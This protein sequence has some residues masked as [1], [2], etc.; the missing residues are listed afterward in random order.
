MADRVVAVPAPSE[1]EAI[2]VELA[3]LAG[4]LAL[5]RR[6]AGFS[7]GTKSSETDVVTDV[8]RAVERF[9]VDELARRRP[10]DIVLGE[11]GGE[12]SSRG[13]AV[14]WIV[15]PID[16]T[17]NFMLGLPVWSVS[18]AAETAEGT[19]AGCVHNPGAG[20]TFH[21]ARGSGAYLGTRR[22]SGPRSVAVSEAVVATGFGY[23][24]GRRARQGEVAGRLLG[25]VGNLR[26]LGSAALDLCALAAGWVD[27]YYEG[28]LNEWDLAAG[29]LI[30]EEA[31]VALSGLRGRPPGPRL[32]AGAH[33]DH[34]AEFF[35]LLEQLGA[36]ETG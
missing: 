25:H 3:T 34:A 29:V 27:M 8:D 17:V 16:G 18:I 15:D 13:S 36:D 33:A 31:G 32:V 22:L 20:A 12:T 10:S 14:R 9:I 24:A 7:V 19:V 28:P 35:G 23:D 26:R 4:Q 11:E 2:A 21:A 5:D 1:L 30:A 6:A